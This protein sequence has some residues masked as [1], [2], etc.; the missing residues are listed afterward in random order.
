MLVTLKPADVVVAVAV[1]VVLVVGLV[2]T[3]SAVE[4]IGTVAVFISFA[5]LVLQRLPSQTHVLILF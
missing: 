2:V 4:F 5:S 3:A 1:V